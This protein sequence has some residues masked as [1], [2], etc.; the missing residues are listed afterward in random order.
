MGRS[1]YFSEITEIDCC[2]PGQAFFPLWIGTDLAA[3]LSQPKFSR[4]PSN[5]LHS[6]LKMG[7]AYIQIIC[8]RFGEDAIDSEH[9][10]FLFLLKC[11]KLLTMI[12][13]YRAH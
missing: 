13:L 1:Y 9:R 7:A 10:P 8:Y 11:L 4:A 12:P 5:R 6:L 3:P 2:V